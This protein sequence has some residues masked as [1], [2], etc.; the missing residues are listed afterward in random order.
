MPTV[1]P[2]GK[3][4]NLIYE[5]NVCGDRA[6]S[7]FK[8]D[9]LHVRID[10]GVKEISDFLPRCYTLTHSDRT[11]DLFLTIA[12]SYDQGQISG[13]YTQLM[14]DEVLAEWQMDESPSLHL[15]CHVSGG[16]VLGPARW[17]DAIFKQ[18][19][20]LVLEAICYG[21]REF[22]YAHPELHQ[23]LIL[24]HF[25]ARQANLNRVK[26]WGFVADY[27]PGAG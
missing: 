5:I 23:A 11:G 15:H 10:P 9:K 13:W 6:M 8:P 25:H 12:P 24:V 14:R 18:H 2:G 22:I 7:S 17:R 27:L 3:R 21:D 1:L 16:L 20:P 26:K 19:L 4:C